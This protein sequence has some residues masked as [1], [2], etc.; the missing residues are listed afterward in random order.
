MEKQKGKRR[1]MM[2]CQL[3][4][5][6]IIISPCLADAAIWPGIDQPTD[7]FSDKRSG[8]L[9]QGRCRSPSC[10]SANHSINH[11]STQRPIYSLLAACLSFPQTNKTR[12]IPPSLPLPTPH[13][14]FFFFQLLL[15]FVLFFKFFPQHYHF[16]FIRRSRCS[17]HAQTSS[18]RHNLP[19]RIRM[20]RSSS[21]ITNDD[22]D[23]ITNTIY[24]RL[25]LDRPFP[26]STT[27]SHSRR[28]TGIPKRRA[29]LPS[30]L[31]P[32]IFIPPLLLLRLFTCRRITT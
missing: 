3:V 9:A 31:P 2:G 25:V 13:H 15:L 26:V 27:H 32:I 29:H 20:G 16:P 6:L 4:V 10:Q 23:N 21:S 30:I 22:N 8:D 1:K 7:A 17:T 24:N 19:S 28:S 11:L 14:V 18:R 5:L 12:P